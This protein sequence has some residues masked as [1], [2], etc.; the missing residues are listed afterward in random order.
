MRICD[1]FREAG[2]WFLVS[3][4][5]FELQCTCGVTRRADA[6]RARVSGAVTLYECKDCGASLIGIADDE[7]APVTGAAGATAPADDDDGHRMC[8]F[9]FGSK[10]EMAMWPPAATEPWMKIPARPR[11]FSARGC[12]DA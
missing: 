4:R 2:F 8:G 12:D 6:L 9:V 3:E 7:R 5:D 1:P 10:V 11:F